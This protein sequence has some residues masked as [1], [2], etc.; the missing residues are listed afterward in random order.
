MTLSEPGPAAEVPS[1][2]ADIDRAFDRLKA[3]GA[4]DDILAWISRRAGEAQRLATGPLPAACPVRLLQAT[5][6]ADCHVN[7]VPDG[8]A[9]DH[10]LEI[11]ARTV[12]TEIAGTFTDPAARS[13]AATNFRLMVGHALREMTPATA[14]PL[15]GPMRVIPGGVA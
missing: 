4:V 5:L 7:R 2:I 6:S 9:I 13:M 8:Q 1:L 15:P 10:R 12:A 14:R 11:L 3:L